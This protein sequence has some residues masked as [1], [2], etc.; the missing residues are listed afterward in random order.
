MAFVEYT[1]GNDTITQS[2]A[3]RDRW[4][5]HWARAGDD[6]LR[7]YQGNAVG[8]PGNDRIEQL[9]FAAEPWRQ[10]WVAYWDS[11]AGVRLHFGEGWAE[12]GHGTRD[13]LVGIQNVLTSSQDD[14]LHGNDQ[15]NRFVPNGGNDTVIGGGGIDTV[16]AWFDAPDGFRQARL[17]EVDITVSPDGRQATVK[18]LVGK[19]FTITATDV[20]RLELWDGTLD[21]NGHRRGVPYDLSNFITPQ[22]MAEQAVVAGGSFRWNAAQP[23]G[24][25][26]ELTYSFVTTAPASG[27]GAAGFRSFDPVEQQLVRDILQRTAA[28]ANIRFT[29]VAEAG[30]TVGQLRFGVSQQ[31]ATKGVSWQPNQ[32]G[33]GELAGDIWMDLESM[34]GLARGTEGYGALLHEIG[35]ALGL[36]HPRNVN[37]GDSHAMQLREQ[38]DRTALTAMSQVASADGLFRTDWGLLDVHALRYLYGSRTT[39][40]GDD[41]Y[42]LATALAGQSTIVDDGGADTIDASALPTGVNLDLRA[43]QLS[44]AGVTLAGFSG[45]ENLGL[46]VGSLIENAV[47]SPHDDVLL[48]NDRDNRL[49]GGAGND[50]IE[51]GAGIDTAVFAG[52]R[53]DYEVST[54][55]GKVFVAGRDGVAGFDT[56]LAVEQLQFSDQRVVLNS[57]TLGTDTR[58]SVDEDGAV[59]ATLP[60]PTDVARSAVTYQLA[61][62]AAH[63]TA[64]ISASGEISYRPASNYHGGD[65][66]AFD[67]VGAGGSNRYVAYVTVLPINDAA[68]VGRDGDFVAQRDVLLQARLPAATDADGDVL[69]YSL[70]AD[71]QH[72]QV[73]L[74]PGGDFAYRPDAGYSGADTFRFTVSDG[75]GGSASYTARLN[76]VPVTTTVMGTAGPDNLAA[77]SSADGYSGLAGDDRITGGGGDDTIDGG[78]GIDTA[79]YAQVRSLYNVA[80]SGSS[81]SVAQKVGSEGTDLVF[82]VERLQFKDIRV[83][84]DLDGAAGHAAQVIRALLGPQHLQN[85]TYVGI[86]LQLFDQGA[87]YASVVELALSVV[88]A[89]AGGSSNADFVRHV[90][91][92]VIGVEASPADVALYAGLIDAG[93]Y[94]QSSL[95]LLACQLPLN[96]ASTDL[97]GLASTGIEFLPPA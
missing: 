97:V 86:G 41:T 31:A 95:G 71:P 54:G 22:G 10:V 82:A 78:A 37:A 8:G 59:T 15:D 49:T 38:D 27:V 32:P 76:V 4:D 96:T 44:S 7:L 11:P 19:P 52:R 57:V 74:E 48:G 46:A 77:R 70:L 88:P 2:E 84:L 25:S 60:D 69:S 36:R 1:S 93:V 87:S 40:G 13:T 83:A 56:L 63:G 91:R 29:E 66:V 23:L 39:A 3:D 67:I 89:F 14:W 61:V 94:T 6:V 55:F 62:P 42:L 81:W 85:E 53:T 58:V 45:V 18:S 90:Y 80:R 34:V 68:P 12:D 26:V 30:G 65:S 17:E 64:S 92:N 73:T 20:E 33:A 43:G 16:S 5:D 79:I 21:S 24:S 75:M 51:G 35:H 72:G 47:G 9:T 28:L 50:W